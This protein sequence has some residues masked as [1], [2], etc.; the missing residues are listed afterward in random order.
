[1]VVFVYSPFTTLL[2]RCDPTNRISL[3]TFPKDKIAAKTW[4][5]KLQIGK[6][7]PTHA[8][9]CSIHFSEDA[10]ISNCD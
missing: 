7:I 6:E 10:F 9:V 2:F 8:R 4:Q 5:N 1:M 3:H